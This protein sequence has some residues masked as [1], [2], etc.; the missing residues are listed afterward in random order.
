VKLGE[1][2]EF[3]DSFRIPINETERQKRIVNKPISSLYP[4]YGANGQV[5]WIDDYL[6]DEPL[7]L[8]AEDGGAFGSTKD[9]IAYKISGK[10]WVNNHAHVL[11]PRNIIDFDYCLYSISI[12][13]D[14][15]NI[16]TGN[17]RPKLNQEIASRILIPLAPLTEQKRIAAIL[18]EQM[19]AIDKAR[20]AAEA[21]LAAA[22]AL[23]FSYVRDTLS[24]GLIKTIK[25]SD[26]LD[27]VTGGIGNSWKQYA[28]LGTT[29][30]GL[31][32][33]KEPPGKHPERY[34]FVGEG[35]IFYNPMRI[36]LGSISF[37]D[38]KDDEGITSPDYVVFKTKPGFLHHRWFYHWLRSPFG[39]RLIRSLA[40]G[41]VRER[42]LFKRLSA[43]LIDIPS[44]EEQLTA[45]EKIKHIG[46]FAER[47]ESQIDEINALPEAL[48]RRAFSGEL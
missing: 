16:V 21:Q 36:L 28:V 12:R 14:I 20:A 29:R 30:N 44:W 32:L 10:T 2:C 4:Y 40:R 15:G 43:G 48:L 33:A 47:I 1:V 24:K 22:K 5:G 34:K 41:A 8:L 9:K 31:S 19:E 6:F 11:R 3:L 27:E 17:T 18:N 37:V 26:C 45:A 7:I 38:R 23:Q 46:P 42:M 13:P 25:L 39:D 35:T